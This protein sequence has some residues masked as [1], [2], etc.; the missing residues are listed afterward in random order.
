MQLIYRLHA[1]YPLNVS[2]HSCDGTSAYCHLIYT[3]YIT[4]GTQQNNKVRRSSQTM[5]A[6]GLS[7]RNDAAGLQV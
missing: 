2:K 1:L 3:S 4:V 7:T 6:A 5:S